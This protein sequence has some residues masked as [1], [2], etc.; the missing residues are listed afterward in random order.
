MV[1][2]L[3]RLG[4]VYKKTKLVPG[5]ADPVKQQKFI[6]EYEKLKEQMK[7]KYEL[8]FM[9]GVHPQ[10]NPISSYGWIPKGQEKEV[11]TNTGRKR[12][13]INGAKNIKNYDVIARQDPTINAQSTILLFQE[14]EHAYPSLR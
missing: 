7:P 11:P 10:H 1:H 9:D 13:N 8:L 6:Q 5:K 2:L 12:I 4:F 3:N 14:I